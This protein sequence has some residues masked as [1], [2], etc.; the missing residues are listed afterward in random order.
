VT[1][2]TLTVARDLLREARARRWVLALFA[3]VTLSLAAIGFGLEL[4]VVDGALA[5]ARLFGGTMDRSIRAADVALRPL[6]EAASWI[7]FYGGLLLGVVVCADFG[8]S[9]LEP[10]RIEALLALPVRRAE[11]L[12]GTFLGVLGLVFLGSLYGGAG[13]ALLIWVKAGVFNAGPIVA[14][15][16]AAIAFSSLYAAMLLAAVA[17]R[18]AALS[19]MAGMAVYFLGL[20]AGKRATLGPLFAPGV[21]RS[22]FLALTAPFPRLTALA[23]AAQ[24]TASGQPLALAAT[25]GLV[26]GTLLFSAGLLAVA[27]ALFERKDY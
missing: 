15:A 8:P 11:L 17:V 9:L 25:A 5:A 13:L 21:G 12:A 19:A 10:G 3:G 7:V 23:D 18:S 20:L 6:F 26:A 27:V 4:E 22:G 2:R 1:A 14:A 16:L 24:A